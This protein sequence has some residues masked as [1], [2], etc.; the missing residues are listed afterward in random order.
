[1]DLVALLLRLN[2]G[3]VEPD[4]IPIFSKGSSFKFVLYVSFPTRADS[5]A[6]QLL[7]GLL[8]VTKAKNLGNFE[9][10]V[11][12][13]KES[14]KGRWDEAFIEKEVDK[15]ISKRKL[16]APLSKLYV[17]GPPAMNETFDRTLGR[18][19]KAGTLR[20]NQVEVM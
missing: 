18:L 14:P 9:L 8:E 13:S 16:V 17:C 1:M 2:L 5:I 19:I 6:L 3:L 15:F 12:I 11:R 7:E 10:V 4:S 20:Q